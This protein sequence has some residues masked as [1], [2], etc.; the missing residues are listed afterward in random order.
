MC[1]RQNNAP[2]LPK[3]IYVPILGTH[4]KRNFPD[5]IKLKALPWGNYP[6]LSGQA[7]RNGI[8]PAIHI[9]K[10]S[11]SQSSAT[12]A[13]AEGEQVSPEGT[14]EGKEYLPFSSPQTTATPHGEP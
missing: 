14:Q 13:T 4:D 3:D 6:G 12:A 8:L 10:Q 7:L 9:S 1:S 5:V 2:D 11:M